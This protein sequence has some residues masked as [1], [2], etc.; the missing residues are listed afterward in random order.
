MTA[1][2]R[3]K[4]PMAE[5]AIPNEKAIIDEILCRQ[6]AQRRRISSEK[7]A[8]FKAKLGDEIQRAGSLR[9]EFVDDLLRELRNGE[10]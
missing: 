3:E 1:P 7:M 2:F 6:G 9:Q 10:L 5:K 4:R 8:I